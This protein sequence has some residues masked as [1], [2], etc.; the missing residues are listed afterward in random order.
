MICQT[1]RK[2]VKYLVTNI[3]GKLNQFQKR[4]LPAILEFC[5]MMRPM[6][7]PCTNHPYNPILTCVRSI[8]RPLPFILSSNGA[9]EDTSGKTMPLVPWRPA[10]LQPRTTTSSCSL[11]RCSLTLS[12][13]WGMRT[14]HSDV[15]TWFHL[16][17]M[18]YLCSWFWTSRS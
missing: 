12:N 2:L 1:Y 11:C 7:P 18:F 17:I 14:S 9:N 13:G 6:F 15:V 3:K 4:K 16:I 5:A 8:W 10:R